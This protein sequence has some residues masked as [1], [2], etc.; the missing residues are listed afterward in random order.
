L[1]GYL[2]GISFEKCEAKVV[3][4]NEQPAG[5]GYQFFVLVLSIYALGVLVVQR[6]IDLQPETR[7]IFDYADYAVCGLF[8]VD[9]LI[10]LQRAPSRW[11]YLFTW[12]WIDLL[13]CIPM[14]D[15]TRWG[16]LARILRVLRLLRGLRATN[17]ITSMVV[18]NR[19]ENAFLTV[20]LA[21]ILLLIFSSVGILQF[22]TAPDSNIKTAEDAI[23]WA[24]TTVTTVGYGD[25]YPVTTEGRMIAVVLM[26]AGVGLFGTFSG[27]LAAWF[28]S[29]P[30]HSSA[31][32]ISQLRDEVN[33]LSSLLEREIHK[34]GQR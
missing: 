20:S 2:L 3:G 22:E 28:L 25:R 29:P 1:Y 15:A 16:R 30:A 10:S 6:V 5:T 23:W 21:A 33:R 11:R 27:L 9:F 32:E 19:S 12:G 7:A 17:L 13:S 26:C 34:E 8:F 14:L 24:F 18:R 31:S 4:P